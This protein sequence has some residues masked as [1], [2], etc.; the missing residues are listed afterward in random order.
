[1]CGVKLH[2]PCAFISVA[3]QRACSDHSHV[4]LAFRRYN[5]APQ[6]TT[7]DAADE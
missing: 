6:A 5:A 3:I 1:M 2:V 4:T 7:D